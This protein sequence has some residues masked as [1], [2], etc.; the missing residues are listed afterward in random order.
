MAFFS[1]L[2]GKPSPEQVMSTLLQGPATQ[3][4]DEMER[5]YRGQIKVYSQDFAP[6]QV[7][8]KGLLQDSLAS[9][10]ATKKR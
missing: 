7:E 8:A 10:R 6:R 2:F 3:M 4:A 5:V 1:S 9:C